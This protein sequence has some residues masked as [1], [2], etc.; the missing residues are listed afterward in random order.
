M[1]FILLTLWF[2]LMIYSAMAEYKY[3]YAVKTLEPEIWNKLGASTT[4]KTMFVFISPKGS[5]L[6]STCTD[7]TVVYRAQKHR[8]AGKLFLGYV[9]LVLMVC[10][11]YFKLA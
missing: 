7:E 11:V 6:L 1:L 8:Q 9:M 5:K 10:I 3:Y 4:L 2:I